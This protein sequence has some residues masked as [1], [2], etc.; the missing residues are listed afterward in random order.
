M[1]GQRVLVVDDDLHI[2]RLL[3]STLT[4][5][6][7]E[8]IEA[9]SAKEA[10]AL[11]AEHKPDAVLLDLG[12]PDRDGLEIVQLLKKASPAPILVLSARDSTDQKVAA[13]DLGAD[14]YVTKPF[15]SEEVLARL[16]VSLRHR[17]QAEGAMPVVRAGDL[18]IDLADRRIMRGDEEI[19]LTRK[20]YEVLRILAASPG[21]VVTHQRALEAAWPREY[22]R[23]I[24]YLR[25]VVRNLRQKLEL[26]P[27]RP[28]LIVNE[29]GV[30][31]RLI[32]DG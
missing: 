14:D 19:H 13:L 31:Y 8:P 2:R 17:L 9:T 30:G 23:R 24:D 6:G 4:R 20:E 32:T 5:G 18:V 27:A 22:D 7:Y 29:L 28:S 26:D 10:L 21:R 11:A 25:I 1:S 3:H 15:D 12:L 16:R